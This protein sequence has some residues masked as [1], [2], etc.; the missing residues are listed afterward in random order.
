[1]LTKVHSLQ[2]SRLGPVKTMPLFCR[3]RSGLVLYFTSLLFLALPCLIAM[4]TPIVNGLIPID[5]DLPDESRAKPLFVLCVLFSVLIILSTGGRIGLKLYKQIPLT[6]AD[7]FAVICFAFNLTANILETEMLKSGFGR[8]LQFLEVHNVYFLR[9]YSQYLILMATIA[10]WAV[11][12][13]VSLFILQLIKGTHK[14]ATRIIYGLI[15]I[16]TLC[17]IGQGIFWGLQARPLQKLWTPDIPGTVQSIETLVR[18]IIIFTCINSTTDL[19]YGLSPI[20]FFGSLKLSLKKK[21]VLIALT[22][23]GLIVFATSIVRVAFDH[24]FYDHDFTWALQRVYLCTVIE[25]NLAE[26]VADLPATFTIVRSLHHKSLS[27]LSRSARSN[28]QGY[29]YNSHDQGSHAHKRSTRMAKAAGYSRD[30]EEEV[31]EIPLRNS[32][33]IDPSSKNIRMDTRIDISTQSVTALDHSRN[34]TNPSKPWAG[35]IGL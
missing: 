15:T 32:E 3:P 35:G 31:D 33:S 17:S 28:I 6:L 21:L 5:P 14:I 10:L 12:I 4:A 11:K 25:R 9:R 29:G 24:D 16:T 34:D 18:S 20:Y 2:R 27:I 1:M 7:G 8:H 23:A 13:S 22:G 19:F 30:L 26:I